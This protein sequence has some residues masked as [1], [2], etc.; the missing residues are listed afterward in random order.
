MIMRMS[1]VPAILAAVLGFSN[2]PH[3][4]IWLWSL[5]VCRS[6]PTRRGD[7]LVNTG[8]DVYEFRHALL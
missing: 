6:Q 4:H 5:H 3:T 1:P 2:L 8:N 7:F